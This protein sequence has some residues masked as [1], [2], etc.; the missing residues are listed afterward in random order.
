MTDKTD[1]SHSDGQTDIQTDSHKKRNP[2]IK[3]SAET[4]IK[5]NGETS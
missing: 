1:D 2:D 4:D 3:I 5:T